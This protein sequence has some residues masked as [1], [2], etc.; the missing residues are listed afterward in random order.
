[1]SE[2]VKT[3]IG[4]GFCHLYLIILSIIAFFPLF[5]I[6]ISSVKS[7][8]EL[9]SNPTSIIPKVFTLENY[10]NVNMNYENNY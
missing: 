3:K 10:K 8:G 9:N 1:M 7:S 2:N 6:I 5:W 4:D